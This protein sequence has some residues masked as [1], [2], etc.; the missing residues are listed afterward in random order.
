VIVTFNAA[1]FVE[2]CL[3][4]VAAQTRL[5]DRVAVVDN[6]STDGT[7]AAIERAPAGRPLR[8][9]VLRQ[10]ENVGFARAN[11]V[12]V[13]MLADCDWVALLNPDAFPEPGWLA[14]LEAAAARHPDAGSLASRLMRDAAPGV[15]DGAGDVYHVSGLGWRH[16]HGQRIDAVP[17]ALVERPVFAA[18]AAAALYRRDDWMAA[19]ALDERYFCYA[20]DVDLGFRL[21]LRERTC[22]YVP[23]A[24]VAHVGSATAGVGSA[25]SIYHG[26]RNL[27]WTFVKDMPS[28]L[29]WR[30]LPVHAL[31]TVVALGWFAIK[32]RGGTIVRAKWDA[33]RGVS[34]ALAARRTVQGSRTLPASTLAARLDRSSLFRRWIGLLTR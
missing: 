10:A 3:A 15:V 26:H 2:R 19:G 24:V 27:A 29:V 25:F 4:A 22:W 34:R 13:T 9:E 11:N 28:P 12:G 20:E 17:E 30:Y 16:G 33:V 23:D 7:V 8:V 21:Q 31:A 32:G 18:C 6:H 1:P 5:P 14:A